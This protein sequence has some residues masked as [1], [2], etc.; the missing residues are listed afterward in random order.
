MAVRL[1]KS[2]QTGVVLPFS[3]AALDNAN[4]REMTAAEVTEY[5]DAITGNKAAA[6]APVVEEAPAESSAPPIARGVTVTRDFS[7]GEPSAAEVLKA[8]ETD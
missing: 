4:V 6:P 7:E 1:L 5:M 3:K 2:L 8:L